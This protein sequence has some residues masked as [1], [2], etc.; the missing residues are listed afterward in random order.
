[1]RLSLSLSDLRD[2]GELQAEPGSQG[3]LF[4]GC[5]HM[6]PPPLACPGR[7]GPLRPTTGLLVVAATMPSPHPGKANEGTT[8]CCAL[9]LS[10]CEAGSPTAQG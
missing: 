6:H 3:V 5:P 1:M 8:P 7:P 4:W 10:L 2:Q 9:R